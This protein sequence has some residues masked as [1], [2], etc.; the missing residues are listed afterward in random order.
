MLCETF[1]RLLK[2]YFAT[3]M[4]NILSILALI[5]SYL[6]YYRKHREINITDY[7]KNTNTSLFFLRA[8]QG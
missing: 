8:Q 7:G 1:L 4:Q 6:C 2:K 3:K 5:A